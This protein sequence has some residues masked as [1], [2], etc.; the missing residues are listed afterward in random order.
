M[1]Q[2]WAH[3][4]WAN[5]SDPSD[6]CAVAIK[7]AHIQQIH[8][9]LRQCPLERIL[10]VISRLYASTRPSTDSDSD[11]DSD[12]P[13]SSS[14][15]EEA[16]L[17]PSLAGLTWLHLTP[18]SNP[19]RAPHL[20]PLHCMPSG[21]VRSPY[22]V[23]RCRRSAQFLPQPVWPASTPLAAT[24]RRSFPDAVCQPCPDAACLFY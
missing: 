8:A 6:L 4:R 23:R 21:A 22:P 9:P 20:P 1:R 16:P 18:E 3:R 12:P 10:E 7:L 14:R 15:P 19:G 11:S 2:Y 5:P 17:L 24:A 13:P